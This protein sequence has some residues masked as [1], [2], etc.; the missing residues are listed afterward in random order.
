[1][2]ENSLTSRAAL[3]DALRVLVEELPREAWQTHRNHSDLVRFWLERHVMFRRLL[4]QIRDDARDM[5]EGEIDAQFY[6]RKLS[7][8]G[9][10]LV[11][12]LHL[13]H[14]IE[15]TQLF[16]VLM[17][18]DRRL[19]AGFDILDKDHHA[20]DDVL[21]GFAE[22]ANGVLNTPEGSDEFS[23]ACAAVKTQIDAMEPML[24][25]HLIDEEEL[26]V[27]VLLKYAPAGLR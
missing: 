17:R 14:R 8:F 22:A 10:L 26:V 18:Q 16:P 4:K 9:G 20:I 11:S 12:E 2:I 23:Q 21:H 13:H 5:L 15:D 3:P 7:R 6:G 19:A 24:N 1:M 25:R 27:P